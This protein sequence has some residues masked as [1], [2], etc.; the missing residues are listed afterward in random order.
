MFFSF[1]S[2]TWFE[3]KKEL[4]ML[5]TQSLLDDWFLCFFKFDSSKLY[6]VEIRQQKKLQLKISISFRNWTNVQYATKI[7]IK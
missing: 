6:A 5:C 4:Q 1:R 3:E 2:I 7:S